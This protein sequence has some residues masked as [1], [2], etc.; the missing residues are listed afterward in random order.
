[1]LFQGRSKTNS[2]MKSR[3]TIMNMRS[4][5]STYLKSEGVTVKNTDEFNSNRLRN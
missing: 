5:E 4:R 2:E 1:M 3:N